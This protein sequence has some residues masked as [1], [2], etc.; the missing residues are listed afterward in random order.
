MSL[1]RAIAQLMSS[2]VYVAKPSGTVGN[3]GL[4]TYGSPA[5]V[6]CQ[7]EQ[8]SKI[9]TTSNGEELTTTHALLFPSVIGNLDRIWLPGISSSDATLARLPQQIDRGNDIKG[10][11]INAWRVY[12]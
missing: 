5:A 6:K 7:I 3:D 12:V 9:I 10:A 8:V 4:P 11:P 1:D 2:T